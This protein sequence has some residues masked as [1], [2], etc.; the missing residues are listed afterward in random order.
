MSKYSSSGVKT[1]N[2]LISHCTAADVLRTLKS[3][4][5]RSSCQMSVLLSAECVWLSDPCVL[6]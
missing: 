3:K 2:Q 5:R 4:V 6:V 1:N